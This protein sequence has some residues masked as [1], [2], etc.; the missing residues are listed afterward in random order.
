MEV[1]VRSAECAA[2]DMRWWGSLSIVEELGAAGEILSPVVR[3][4]LL[5]QE[6][7]IAELEREVAELRA[8][9]D[10]LAHLPSQLLRR[11]SGAHELDDLPPELRRIRRS[12]LPS[13]R[14]LLFMN[15][16]VSTKAGQL[17]LHLQVLLAPHV[18][19]G[20]RAIVDTSVTNSV[21]GVQRRADPRPAGTTARA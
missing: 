6:T 2:K 19:R 8:A 11:V 3:A 13:H 10:E 5:R 16:Q 4:V 14:G 17:H 7:R 21:S 20:H 12:R 15:D 1:T 9:G 18:R